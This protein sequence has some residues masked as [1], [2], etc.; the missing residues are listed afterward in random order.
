MKGRLAA[1]WKI[2]P[3]KLE[4]RGCR[5][6]NGCR[7]HYGKCDTLDCVKQKK[8][9]FCF[10]CGEFPCTMLQPTANLAEKLPHNLKVFNLCRIKAV[11][12]E[13]WAENEARLIRQ[14]YFKGKMVV[15]KGPVLD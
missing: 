6:Q 2:A 1:Y 15:G 13:A 4:C 11:G 7:L 12:V 5:A 9:E 10:E 14:R 3:E 8:V